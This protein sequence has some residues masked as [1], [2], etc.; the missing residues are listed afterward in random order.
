MLWACNFDSEVKPPVLVVYTILF[1]LQTLPAH[2]EGGFAPLRFSLWLSEW[3]EL[4][5]RAHSFC[6]GSWKVYACVPTLPLDVEMLHINELALRRA[7]LG[8]ARKEARI[9]L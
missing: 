3:S 6:L 4:V 1:F 2:E 7:W 8:R 5:L 9:I